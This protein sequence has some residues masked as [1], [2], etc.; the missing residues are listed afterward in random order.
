MTL[1]LRSLALAALLLPAAAAAQTAL[2][3][4]HPDLD[5]VWMAA[6]SSVYTLRI[7]E[8]VQMDV[9]VATIT[10]TTAGGVATLVSSILIPQ[11]NMDQTTT[12]TADAGSLRPMAHASTGG[13]SQATLVFTDAG[14]SGHI[15]EDGGE[16]PVAAAFAAPAFDEAWTGALAQSLPLRDGYTAAAPVYE[17]E[18]GVQTVTYTVSGPTDEAGVAVWTVRADTPDGPFTFAV[19][20]AT[21]RLER[22]SF[23]PQAGVTIEMARA[24]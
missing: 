14:V 16:T 12:A 15:T 10:T 21:R 6:D 22:M 23:S 19:D 8:P 7:T 1:I 20:G 3:P 13:P 11:Q 2:A 5:T 9:G 18:G 4:G 24:R 17:P